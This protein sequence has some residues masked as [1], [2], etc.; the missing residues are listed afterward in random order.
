MSNINISAT[1]T[2][3]GKFAQDIVKEITKKPSANAIEKNKSA[4][5]LVKKLKG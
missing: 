3:S 2:V 5:E 4:S 1:P